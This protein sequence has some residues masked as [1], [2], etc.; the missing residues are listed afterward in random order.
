MT[1]RA[2][3]RRWAILNALA[4]PFALL[5]VA[6][7]GMKLNRISESASQLA[8]DPRLV[9]IGGLLEV[10]LGLVMFFQPTR[11]P[12]AVTSSVWLAGLTAHQ[13]I[14]GYEGPI[15]ISA[16][17]ALGSLTIAVHERRHWTSTTFR[18]PQPLALPPAGAGSVAAFL[19]PLVGV[20]FLVRWAIGGTAFWLAIP[21]LAYG[22]LAERGKLQ[23]GTE[24]LRTLLTYL[25]VLGIGVSSWWGFVG[26]YFMSDAVAASVGWDTGSPFQLELAFYHLGFG[27]VGLM[28]LW[29]RDDFWMAVIIPVC[30]FALGAA[31]VHV[32][33]YLARGNT[34]P[35]NW[36]FPMFFGDAIIPVA[37]LSL[38]W[39]YRR[40]VAFDSTRTILRDVRG[41]S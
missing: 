25:L 5:I 8:M 6:M 35:G 34:A 4:P 29:F 2:E 20:S 17:L 33:D 11:F 18:F 3:P 28:C 10:I 12:A 15:P 37:M 23:D 40:R 22:D 31:S 39:L 30:V 24:V 27:I 26:H 32:A 21:L 19:L 41:R 14:N 13:L 38:L 9:I 7:G 1:A 36:G 16:V